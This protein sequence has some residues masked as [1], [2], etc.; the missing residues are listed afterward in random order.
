MTKTT[1]TAAP[2]VS[3]EQIDPNEVELDPNIRTQV[4]LPPEFVD[5]IRAEGVREPVLAR[6]TAEGAV[7]VYDG[8]RR[9]LAAREAGVES[10][11]AVF[12]LEDATGSESGRIQDQLRTFAR[13]DLA[14]TDRIAA[15]EQLA[16]DGISV[17][18]IAKSAGQSAEHV[19]GALTVAKSKTAT[20]YAG[21]GTYSLDR[22]MLIAEF[23][24]DDDAISAVTDC[25]DD[26]LE[27]VAQEQRDEHVIRVR[28]AE[29]VAQYEAQGLTVVTRYDWSTM[30]ELGRLTDA[31]DDADERPTLDPETHAACPG[32]VVRVEVY[33]LDEGDVQ[34]TAYCTRKELHRS[35]YRYQNTTA[36]AA[37]DEPEL[38]AEEAEARAEAEATAKR[39]ARRTLIANNKAWDTATT[40][41]ID[42]LKTLLSR[43]KLPTGVGSFVAVTMTRHRWELSN[44]NDGIAG[45]LLGITGYNNRE[46]MAAQV[47][48]TPTR[49]AYVSLAVALSAREHATSRESW[50]HPRAEHAAYLRQLETWGYHLSP[51]ERIAAGY[52]PDPEP[53]DP[54]ASTADADAPAEAVEVESESVT[55]EADAA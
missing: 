36:C 23:E 22:L 28:Q 29:L 50:R 52:E 11:L 40:V 20:Q 55:A 3:I 4:V 8:Q 19:T 35:I 48:K 15:Y 5:S 27:F 10:M 6:R 12:G 21:Y 13:A 17:E 33:G 14:L 49:A 30:T 7:Y 43:K 41:R 37:S 32:H 24:G 45:E 31:D 51:V 44:D 53:T 2:V 42:W 47:E 34:V 39:E 1:K 26:D 46:A 25:D 9:L 38:T 16:L 54:E 18:K